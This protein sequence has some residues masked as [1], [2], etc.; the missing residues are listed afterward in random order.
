M[1]SVLGYREVGL[2]L[3]RI[4]SELARTANQNW[5]WTR[6][7]ETCTRRIY[8]G[9]KITAHADVAKYRYETFPCDNAHKTVP[10]YIREH[11]DT[12]REFRRVLLEKPNTSLEN[13]KD[14]V[15]RFQNTHNSAYTFYGWVVDSIAKQDLKQQ[16]EKEKHEPAP[17]YV[18]LFVDTPGR[19]LHITTVGAEGGPAAN[20]TTAKSAVI[21]TIGYLDRVLSGKTQARVLPWDRSQLQQIRN[22]LKARIGLTKLEGEGVAGSALERKLAR[23]PKSMRNEIIGQERRA[24]YVSAMN[25]LRLE[26]S[27]QWF[28][29]FDLDKLRIV[30]N[31]RQLDAMKNPFEAAYTSLGNPKPLPVG[32]AAVEDFENNAQVLDQELKQQ[33]PER[34][35]WYQTPRMV[36]YLMASMVCGPTVGRNGVVES[37]FMSRVSFNPPRIVPHH[38]LC[39]QDHVAM[40]DRGNMPRKSVFEPFGGSANMLEYVKKN[41]SPEFFKN[42]SDDNVDGHNFD[43]WW[44]NAVAKPVNTTV[45]QFEMKFR[46]LVDK[47]FVPALL[48]DTNRLFQPQS[49]YNGKMYSEILKVGNVSVSIISA[50]ARDSMLTELNTYI[51]LATSPYLAALKEKY[52]AWKTTQ[53][54]QLVTEFKAFQAEKAK[55]FSLMQVASALIGVGKE[56]L[57]IVDQVRKRANKPAVDLSKLNAKQKEQEVLRIYASV[58][59]GYLNSLQAMAKMAAGSVKDKTRQ[60]II[61][62]S[63]KQ[64]SGLMTEVDSYVLVMNSV[65]LRK[66]QTLHAE[67][68]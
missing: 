61:A 36:D 22:A 20:P 51:W 9:V 15:L 41:V 25:M 37:S 63:L 60:S 16:Y 32:L 52:P 50:N 68:F 3:G 2:K 26:I 8:D 67:K 44:N 10:F 58:K 56:T 62:E 33:K 46:E 29:S 5:V 47:E 53:R 6:K 45:R 28:K 1:G 19:G 7:N 55:A 43:K 39:L 40:A 48:G 34:L 54:K 4:R 65:R 57:W 38:E 31:D 18:P 59:Q 24:V 11:A 64:M 42:V 66:L 35:V 49:S 17:F 13:W 27:T 23:Y 30:Q 12:H 21:R 14:Y